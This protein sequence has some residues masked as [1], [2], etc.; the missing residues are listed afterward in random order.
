MKTRPQTSAG[1]S[2]FTL[3]ELLTVIAIIAIL[4]GLL[5]PAIGA[6]KENA[7]RVQAKNDLMQIVAAVKHYYTEYGKM[8]SLVAPGGGGGANQS[9]SGSGEAQDQW[10]GDSVADAKIFNSALF[11]TLRAIPEEPNTEHLLNPRKIIFFEGRSATNPDAPRAG[12]LDKEKEGQSGGA[13]G[14]SGGS[15]G[16]LKGCFFDPWGKQYCIMIDTN[17]DN[18]LD[19]GQCYTDFK[20]ND[21]KPRTQV[22]AF[23]LG[24]DNKLGDNGNKKYRE[25]QKKSDD[26]ISW[27]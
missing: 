1:S 27:D 21:D 4:M 3:I 2:A 15:G 6:V 20:T 12:F 9:A 8:P 22:G 11:N 5:F 26:V 7:R 17:F 24:K 25:G 10:V 23:S 18:R 19:M 16:A 14:G 13:G